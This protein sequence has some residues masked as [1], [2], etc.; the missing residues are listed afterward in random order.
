MTESKQP[1]EV[2]KSYLQKSSI[3]G[4]EEKVKVIGIGGYGMKLKNLDNNSEY[5]VS[6]PRSHHKYYKLLNARL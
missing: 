2:G 4:A 1:L 5:Y 6:N 3:T